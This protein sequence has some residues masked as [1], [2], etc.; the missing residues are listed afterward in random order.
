[1]LKKNILVKLYLLEL[2]KTVPIFTTAQKMKFSIKYVFSKCDQIANLIT[3]TE[4]MLNKKLYFLCSVRRDN[5]I[6]D[7]KK[8]LS[9]MIRKYCSQR[10]NIGFFEKSQLNEK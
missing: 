5:R 3:F 9:F 4:E 2:D 10:W 7:N 6:D 8:M 1:M